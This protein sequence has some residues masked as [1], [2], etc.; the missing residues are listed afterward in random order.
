MV[1]VS[2]ADGP[3]EPLR[4]WS[5]DQSHQMGLAQAHKT[6]CNLQGVSTE[7][8]DDFGI[9]G[10]AIIHFYHKKYVQSWNYKTACVKH[11]QWIKEQIIVK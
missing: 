11:G 10:T 8:C 1:G 3:C 7:Q 5:V 6:L 4:P 2:L 9:T